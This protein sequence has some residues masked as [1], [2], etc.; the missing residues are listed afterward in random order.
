MREETIK[1]LEEKRADQR[2]VEET[3]RVEA[4]EEVVGDILKYGMSFMR[5]T[6][7]MIKKKE[8]P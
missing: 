1:A 5:S 8:V 7:F 4:K 6:L 2:V 3:I